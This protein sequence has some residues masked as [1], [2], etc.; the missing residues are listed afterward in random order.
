MEPGSI[1]SGVAREIAPLLRHLGA[2][3]E[4]VIRTAGLDP[5]MLTDPN[6]T[7]PLRAFCEMIGRSGAC[8][9]CAH[10][11]LLLGQRVRVASLGLVGSLM[12][13]S[14]TVGAAL[15]GLI[16]HV[17]MHCVGAT[18]TLVARGGTAVWSCV[19]YEPGTAC[20][21]QVADA[22]AAAGLNVLRAL[23]GGNWAPEEVL[24]PRAVPEDEPAYRRVFAAPVR[25]NREA[26]ALVF[27]ARQLDQPI[28][29]ADPA[30][31]RSVRE[32]L[33]ELTRSQAPDF[34]SRLRQLLR[35]ELMRGSCTAERVAGL[36][37]MHRRTLA[38]RLRA[39]GT[40]FSAMA[41]EG[42]FEIARQLVD[43]TDIPFAQIAAALGFS[44]ASAF[45]RAFRRWSGQSPTSWRARHR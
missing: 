33:V 37:S 44:E 24:L 3:F 21:D 4:R 45:T 29:G 32:R 34:T 5:A 25:F 19:I 11:G 30:V 27:P 20:A 1:P 16:R 22:A 38:R 6:A 13:H 28:P 43:H 40:A 41:D 26:A 17:E 14:E 15:R 23:C 8:T 18:T 10:F 12:L 35:T 2:D 42:R 31:L 9:G 39:Q 7:I 36:L